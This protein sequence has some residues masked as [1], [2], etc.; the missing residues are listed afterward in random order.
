MG[1][2]D[3][4]E[5]ACNAGDPGS[6]RGSGRFPWRRKWQPK[7]SCLE[8]S[9]DRGTWWATVHGV[10]KEL[11]ATERL[12]LRAL[13]FS[14]SYLFMILIPA[15]A[16]CHAWALTHKGVQVCQFQSFMGIKTI[17][18]WR[19][20]CAFS[21][22]LCTFGVAI[23]PSSAAA[24]FKLAPCFFFFKLVPVGYFGFFLFSLMVLPSHQGLWLW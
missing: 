20:Y 15:V 3:D 8:N 18:S 7:Y 21:C 9:M 11:A 12:T 14:L 13:L 5:S 6:I 1:G 22:C 16:P 17:L 10:T 4:K 2:S 24:I 23:P 19:P